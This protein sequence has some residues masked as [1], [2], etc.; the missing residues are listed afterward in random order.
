M[1]DTPPSSCVVDTDGLRGI[2]MSSGNLKGILVEHLKK[3]TIGVPTCAWQEFENLYPELAV[4]LKA[5]V[6]KRIIIKQAYHIGAAHIADKLN[7]GF[8]RGSYDDN[9]ELLTASIAI[10]HE[11]TILTSEAQVP[12][13]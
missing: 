1:T 13:Y 2:A 10:S 4:S 9:I 5:Q 12:I 11:Y 6:G 3:G 7:S 8:P